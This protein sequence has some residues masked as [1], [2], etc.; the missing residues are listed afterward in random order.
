PASFSQ[1]CASVASNAANDLLAWLES[2]LAAARQADEKVWLLFHV[3]PG[4]DVAATMHEHESLAKEGPSPAAAVCRKAAVP[5]WNPEMTSQFDSLL[6]NYH[7][8]VIASFA[9]HTHTDD[10]RLIGGPGSK[11]EFVLINPPIS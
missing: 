8:T 2:S 10:F 7:N 9:G 4:I 3:P 5:L 6:E 1:G 11:Q